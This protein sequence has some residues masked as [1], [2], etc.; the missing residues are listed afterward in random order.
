MRV[1]RV[2]FGYEIRFARVGCC[3]VRLFQVRVQINCVRNFRFQRVLRMR[4]LRVRFACDIRFARVGRCRVR[5][6]QVRG[7]IDRVRN[8][9]FQRV[10]RM[11]VLRARFGIDIGLVRQLLVG[12]NLLVR[13]RK[14]SACL[15]LELCDLVMPAGRD[16]V[17]NSAEHRIDNRRHIVK[18]RNPAPGVERQVHR[19]RLQRP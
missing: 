3:R 6:F 7:Q 8:F 15:S 16:A 11:R 17:K 1:L 12:V 9:R 18:S 2:R 5:L 4:V 10:L 19:G 13:N 14:W